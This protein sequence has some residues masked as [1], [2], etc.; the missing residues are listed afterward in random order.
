MKYLFAIFTLVAVVL[1][2]SSCHRKAAAGK[3]TTDQPKAGAVEDSTG[4]AEQVP[5]DGVKDHGTLVLVIKR[6]PCYGK[7]P[8]YEAAFYDN[9]TVLY[10]GKKFVAHTG[11]YRLESTPEVVRSL[12]RK[13]REIG[14][15]NMA[16]EY[17][18]DP[19]RKITDLPTTTI[20]VKFGRTAKTVKMTNEMP[21][22][23]VEFGHDIDSVLERLPFPE[24]KN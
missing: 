14:F 10:Y 24:Q 20:M 15:M 1:L 3:H 21:V 9:G 8:W 18:T 19:N 13:A 16:S 2:V 4:F 6:G 12:L 23:L 11:K 5:I 17:P 7:C 22:E